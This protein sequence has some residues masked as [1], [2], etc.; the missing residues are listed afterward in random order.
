MKQYIRLQILISYLAFTIVLTLASASSSWAQLSSEKLVIIVNS[1]SKE[2]KELAA[3]YAEK[4]KLSQTQIVALDLP[5]EENISREDYVNKLVQPLRSELTARKLLAHPVLVTTYGVP[6]RIQAPAQNE[7][8][9]AKVRELEAIQAEAYSQLLQV[10]TNLQKIAGEESTIDPELYNKL[11]RAR[12]LA[13]VNAIESKLLTELNSAYNKAAQVASG[14][15]DPTQRIDFQRKILAYSIASGGLQALL[16]H[17][18]NASQKDKAA[19]QPALQSDA[20]KKAVAQINGAQQLVL[21]LGNPYADAATTPPL[22]IIKKLFGISGMFAYLSEQIASL[23]GADTEAAL[24]SELSLLWWD[25]DTFNLAGRLP[26]PIFQVATRTNGKFPAAAL[27]VLMVSRIDGPSLT[28]AKGI[29]DSSIF[30]EENGLKGVAYFDSRGAK[31]EANN[32]SS[33]EIASYD[34]TILDAAEL[35][36]NYTD[37]D[38][39]VENTD[40]RFSEPGAADDTAVY[41]GWYKLRSYENAFTFKPGAI[42]FHIASEEA[43]SLHRTDEPG[44]CKNALERGI[45]ATLGAVEEPYLDAFPNSADF[46][47]LLLTGKFSLVEAY[48]LTIPHVSWRMVLIGDPLYQPWKNKALLTSEQF[49]KQ[50]EL[51]AKFGRFPAQPADITFDDPNQTIANV[52]AK[53][54]QAFNQLQ[55]LS[56]EIENNTKSLIEGIKGQFKP[57]S[58]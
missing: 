30:A 52:P 16:Q 31:A 27:P 4:R 2:S 9:K 43:V 49:L 44:W 42:G 32:P 21:A 38:V 54:K 12:S 19:N 58:Q 29:I 13:E 3:Y 39:E 46:F 22:E 51:F 10:L 15:T 35:F 33:S 53:R 25:Q 48:F 11:T 41:V 57:A 1:N 20:I 50:S 37:Y 5:L 7:S 55:A 40:K 45:T 26:N 36:R 47:G 17:L 6:L 8:I 23:K 56:I 28:V 24:D 18:L 34:K 14:L